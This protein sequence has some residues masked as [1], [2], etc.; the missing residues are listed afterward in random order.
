MQ[1]IL[2]LTH[3][4]Q[5]F[6]GGIAAVADGLARGA[7]ANGYRVIVSAPDYG[8]NND[9]ADRALPFEVRRFNGSTCSMVSL[10]GLARYA[11]RCAREID[12]AP[13]DLVHAVDPAPQM[14]LATLDRFRRVPPFVFTVH[15]TELLRYRDEF[16]PRLWMGTGLRRAQSVHAVSRAVYRLL[17]SQP[18]CAPRH[19]FIEPP[20][21]APIWIGQPRT[22]RCSARRRWGA[23]DDDLVLFTLAR[24]V[25][26]K[27]HAE[28]IAAAGLLPE[29]LCRRVVYV[30]AGDGPDAYAAQLRETAGRAGVRLVLTGA[31]TD[32]EAIAGCDAADVF[33][34]LS[35][36]TA[37]RM[38]GFGIAYL[39]AGARGLPSVARETGGA[40]EAVTHGETGLVLPAAADASRVASALEELLRDRNLRD[41]MGAC[42]R[43]RA[44][45]F[46][47]DARAR[48]IYERFF[49]HL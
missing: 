33:V 29:A 36:K 41:R 45:G 4:F 48:A 27:G 40:A 5:P 14:A 31:L 20:G 35:R 18:R 12:G 38:E 8:T 30:V 19:A 42:A 1:T 43:S 26:E 11:R 16:V 25:P 2:I 47:W 13:A 6:R 22:D 37:T 17:P 9:A 10:D 15:G 3:E 32:A 34:M 23:E 7:S 24:R 49:S 28:V 21:I 39:E 46:L 44:A